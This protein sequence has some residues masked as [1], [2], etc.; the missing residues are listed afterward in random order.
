MKKI[1]ALLITL[2]LAL[3]V[4]S[5]HPVGTGASIGK[6]TLS[7]PGEIIALSCSNPY[8]TLGQPV[9]LLVTIEGNAGNQ[10]NE[11]VVVTDEFN[12]LVV[13]NGE[14]GWRS[15]NVTENQIDITV[16][17]L[18]QY[19]KKIAWYPSVV[20]NHTFH[21]FVGAFP[22]KQLNVSVGFDV[23][24]IIAP[25]LGCPSIIIKN[26]TNQMVVTISEERTISEEPVQVLQV[27]LQDIDSSLYYHIENHS[28]LWRT[29]IN[30]G[31]NIL[32]DELIVSYPIDSIP[33]GFY[34]ISVTT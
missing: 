31:T 28:A 24:G 3:P 6:A 10:F 19:T 7:S 29:W 2:F 23:E 16:G 8:P 33:D 26:D 25:S 27:E 5:L 1:T 21:V 12:G 32:E 11:T 18:P 14:I 15:G 4:G 34:N 30:A 13:T 22:E 17:K 20:G 9:Y